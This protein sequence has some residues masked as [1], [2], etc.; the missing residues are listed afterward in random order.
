MDVMRTRNLDCT[1]P[2]TESEL[3]AAARSAWKYEREGRNLVGQGKAIIIPHNLLD[4]LLAENPD[5]FLLMTILKRHHWGRDFVLSNAMA[6]S[7]NWGTPSLASC[8]QFT[9]EMW[10]YRLH[11]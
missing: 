5:A 4:R 6:S 2:L 1:L 7:L 10:R 11:P 9:C 3:E 8:P